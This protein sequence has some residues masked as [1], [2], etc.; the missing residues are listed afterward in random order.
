MA[1]GQNM[2]WEGTGKQNISTTLMGGA[3]ISCYEELILYQ[4]QAFF[5][6]LAH[7]HSGLNFPVYARIEKEEDVVNVLLKIK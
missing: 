2:Q 7:L 3:W 6:G 1:Q 5:P 4:T